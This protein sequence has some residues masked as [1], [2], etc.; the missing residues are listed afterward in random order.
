MPLPE[1]QP[2]DAEAYVQGK[3]WRTRQSGDQ[4][5]IE[6][7]PFCAKQWK[8]YLSS[9]S[10]LWDCKSG[11]CGRRGNFYQLKKELGDIQPVAPLARQQ[12]AQPA[13]RF[14]I[15]HLETFEQALE[16]DADAQAYLTGRGLTKDAW[17]AWHLGVKTDR[18]VKWLMI[19]YLK[20]TEVVDIKY[21]SLPPEEKRFYRFRNGE[22]ILFGSHQ[23]EEAK[24]AN[25]KTLILC[26]GEIDAI[27]LSQQGFWPAVSTTTG[28][29]SFPS[30]WYDQILEFDP[31][32]IIICY[33]SDA[34]GQKA[35]EK[36]LAKFDDRHCVN[37][38]LPDAKDANEYFTTHTAADFQ[39]LIDAAKPPEVEDC[40][41]L[42][43]VVDMLEEQLWLS[44]DAFDGLPSMFPD[45]NTMIA[46]GYWSGQLVTLSGISGTGKTSFVLQELLNWAKQGIPGYLLC[47]EMPK[48]MMLRKIIS[49]EYGVPILGIQK[50]HV[51]K[52]RPSLD[53]LPLHLG[54]HGNDLDEIEKKIRQA[55]KRYDIKVVALDNLNYFVRSIEHTTQEISRVTKRM[56]ELAVDLNIPIIQIA[57][58]RKFDNEK[59]IMSMHDL[60]DSSSIAQDSDTIILLHRQA[61]RSDINKSAAGFVGALSPFT[62]VRVDKARYSG[63]GET[64]L[65]FDGARSTYRELSPSEKDSMAKAA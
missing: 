63:G 16:A 19:P 9:T 25:R 6:T 3:G 57:Q 54:Q 32:R 26:E 62:L 11:A 2:G 21:R 61:V 8:L 39:G 58:P 45:V 4:L 22:S 41:P 10:G 14:E 56:K 37:I 36:L 64:V 29:A 44:S 38:V 60:K 52:F 34:A 23:F 43:R 15:K 59:R 65:W 30:K 35:A 55:V 50:E 42:A 24:K 47:L 31:E 7:C 51:A 5:I 20:G 17:R 33:D 28:A 27:S 12:P 13:K 1:F 18:G 48:V 40:T 53:K 46:G 49:K